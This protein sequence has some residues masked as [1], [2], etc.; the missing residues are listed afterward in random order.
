MLDGTMPAFTPEKE[1]HILT[2][3]E[4]VVHQVEF[5]LT[6]D[7]SRFLREIAEYARVTARDG[8][9]DRC[10]RAIGAS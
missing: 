5:G 10:R 2:Q 7:T 9:P 4:F 6:D 3:Q 1:L 8:E